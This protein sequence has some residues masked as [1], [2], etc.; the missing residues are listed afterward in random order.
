VIILHTI[1]P[2]FAVIRGHNS[3]SFPLTGY[4]SIADDPGAILKVDEHA[5]LPPEALAL[6]D[7]D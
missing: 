3:H 7:A 2:A 1:D 5:L 4:P 6:S